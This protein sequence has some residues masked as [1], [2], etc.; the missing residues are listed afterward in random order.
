VEEKKAE[1]KKAEKKDTALT[2]VKFLVVRSTPEG[3]FAPD[4]GKDK[5][6]VYSIPAWEALAL[7]DEGAVE[8]V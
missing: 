2:K 3:F 5:N 7:A 1:E 6:G 8:L 4:G